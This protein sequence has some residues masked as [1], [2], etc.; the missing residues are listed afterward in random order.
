[1]FFTDA[2]FRNYYEELQKKMKSDFPEIQ[3]KVIIDDY[4]LY[5]TKKI[6]REIVIEI[7][8]EQ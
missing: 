8:F 6:L 1:M 7:Y 2:D 4:L 3:N 5:S